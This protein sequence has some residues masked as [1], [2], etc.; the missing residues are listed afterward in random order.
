MCQLC[1]IMTTYLV[2]GISWKANSR[3]A[4]QETPRLFMELRDSLM[5]SEKPATA[6]YPDP[7]ETVEPW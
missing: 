4:G 6:Y 3:S 1:A 2:Q 5:C 7:D